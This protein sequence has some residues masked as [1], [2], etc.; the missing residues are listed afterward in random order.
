MIEH[1][2]TERD[3]ENDNGDAA[4]ISKLETLKAEFVEVGCH[5]IAGIDGA[6]AHRKPRLAHAV[7][8]DSTTE[9]TFSRPS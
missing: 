9:P 5:R 6:I 1:G 3:K 7:N 2:K 4:A 8:C